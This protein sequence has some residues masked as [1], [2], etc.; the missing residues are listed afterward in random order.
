MSTSLPPVSLS[1]E[2]WVD[3]YAETGLTIGTK[4]IIQNRRSDD[5]ILSES[6]LAPTGL[7]ADLGANPL[8]GKQFFTNSAGNVGAWAYSAKGGLLQVEVAS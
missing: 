8:V 1:P 2:T 7:I 5:V 3:I 4:L 6:V